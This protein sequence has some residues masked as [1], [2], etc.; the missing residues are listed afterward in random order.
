MRAS[1]TAPRLSAPLRKS[2]KLVWKYGLPVVAAGETDDNLIRQCPYCPN[3]NI[4]EK[5]CKEDQASGC[6]GPVVRWQC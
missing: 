6:G 3:D 4:A 5:C 2:C 1:E